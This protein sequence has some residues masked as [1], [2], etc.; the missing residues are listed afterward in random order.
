M[1]RGDVFVPS[2]VQRFLKI[3]LGDAF[4]L[5]GHRVRLGGVLNASATERLRHL[6]GQSILPVNF[7]DA[8]RSQASSGGSTPQ[9]DENQ[10]IMSDESDRNFVHLSSDQVVVGSASLVQ[11]LGGKLHA[12]S[13][14]PGSGV[15]PSEQGHDWAELVVMPVWAASK[16]GVQRLIFTVLTEVSGGLALFIPLL[17]GG[18]IIFGT[19]LGSISDREREIYTFSALGLSPGHVG[20][21]F[22]A[23][24]AVYAI[25]GGVGG[26]LLAQCVGLVQSSLSRAG[27]IRP[28]SINYSSTNSL[29]AMA[30]VMATVLISAIYPALRASKSANPGLARAWRLPEPSGDR[31]DLMFPFTVSAFDITGAVSFLAEHLR[32]HDDA[33]FGDFAASNVEIGKNDLGYLELHVELALAPFDLGVTEHMTL[34]AI[35]SEIVGVDEVSVKILRRSGTQSDW[36]RANRVFLKGLRQQF[37]LWRTLAADAIEGYRMRTLQ[38]LAKLEPQAPGA[39]QQ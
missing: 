19:L 28:A 23:E 3:N 25:V 31:L 20:A 30:V 10:L 12:I 35:P 13:V 22:F 1:K 24:A 6:D 21:L 9:K 4:I 18:L 5:N 38:E 17:L 36:L 16:D 33:G 39:S 26:Q 32:H 14:Y 8:A 7:Q 37:L 2:I 15:N 34:T 29:F 27:L 11:S